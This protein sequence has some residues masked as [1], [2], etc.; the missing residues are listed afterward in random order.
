MLLD[1]KVRRGPENMKL[2][3]DGCYYM[4][5]QDGNLIIYKAARRSRASWQ[6][7][8]VRCLDSSYGKE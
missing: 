7:A 6:G 3:R 5:R 2:K 4:Q 1:A 8:C